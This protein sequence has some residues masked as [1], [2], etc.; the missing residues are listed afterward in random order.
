MKR[1]NLCLLGFGNVGQALLRLL[2]EQTPAL[3]AEYN[4]EWRLTGLASR[5]LGMRVDPLGIDPH[6]ISD[7]GAPAQPFAENA[8]DPWL[9]AAGADVLFEATS[10]DIHGGE[11][12]LSYLRTALAA[13]VHAITANKGP[14]VYGYRELRDLAGANGVRFR[15]ESTVMDGA[16]IFSLFRGLPLISVEGFRGILNS[17]TNL[18]LAEM[19]RGATFDAG[20]AEAQRRGL[21][22]TD[23]SAD[24]DGWDATVKVSALVQVLMGVPLTPAA[25]PRDGIRD[26]EPERVRAARAAGRPY[27]LIC[28]ATRDGASVE[29]GVEPRQVPAGD[30][31]A[32][33]DGTSSAIHFTTDMLP[34]LTVVEHA[35]TPTTTAYGMLADFVD[36]VGT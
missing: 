9:R 27:K 35:P 36:I 7:P 16:P 20:V 8:I 10:L 23:P 31:L 32:T 3:P 15:F 25:I 14:L 21:A 33:V 17:T 34:G 4:V 30:P 1:Y 28:W 12:A 29:A 19:E 13:G 24:V 5:R 18:I 22:E 2:Q 11:P 6:A 26:L